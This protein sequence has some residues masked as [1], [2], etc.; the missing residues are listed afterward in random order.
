VVIH[1]GLSEV[2]LEGPH[3]VGWNNAGRNLKAKLLPSESIAQSY[4]TIGSRADEMLAVHGTSDRVTKSLFHYG[5][6]YVIFDR[7]HVTEVSNGNPKLKI[8]TQSSSGH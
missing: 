8:K 3:V 5:T 2:N 1:D 7:G 4:F 6:S